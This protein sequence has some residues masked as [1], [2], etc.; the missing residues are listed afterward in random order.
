[1]AVTLCL[2]ARIVQGVSGFSWARLEYPSGSQNLDRD[3]LGR[4]I[5]L[6]CFWVQK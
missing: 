4:L 2:V 5:T 1:M 6:S 3:L